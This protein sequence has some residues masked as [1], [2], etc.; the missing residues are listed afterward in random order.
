MFI[1]EIRLHNLCSTAMAEASRILQTTLI[2][3]FTQSPYQKHKTF[4]YPSS[5]K[6]IK[7]VTTRCLATTT[8]EETKKRASGGFENITWG[9]EMDSP[10]NASGLQKWLY[11]SGLPAQKMGIEKVEV[12]ER[13]LV[14]L[15]NI[16]RG[17]KLL[18][19]PPSLFITADSVLFF[20]SSC[21]CVCVNVCVR[22]R[23]RI[24][25]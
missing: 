22:A 5:Q 1:H 23:E 14:A 2:S 9:C 13:G 17:E 3:T 16:R 21:R 6:L 19:V 18:F 4:A 11:S 25:R 8:D 15:T 20:S 24:K 12:G 7:R 10:E